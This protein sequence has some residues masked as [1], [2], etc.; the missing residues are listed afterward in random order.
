VQA[1]TKAFA[2]AVI[3]LLSI[4]ELDGGYC[5][6]HVSRHQLYNIYSCFRVM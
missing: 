4:I 2:I 6:L 5:G 1:R 3:L